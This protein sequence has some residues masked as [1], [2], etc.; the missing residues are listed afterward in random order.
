[1]SYAPRIESGPGGIRAEHALFADPADA[2]PAISTTEFREAL[3]RAATAVTVIATDG[4]NGVA[5]LTC[6][7]VC[8]VCDTP[9]TILFCVNR[10]SAANSVIKANGVMSVNW[11]SA[12]Q[13]DVSQLF[14]GAGQVPMKERFSSHRW[15]SFQTGTPYSLDALVAL[16]CRISAA[17]EIGTHSVFLARVLTARQA[18]PADPLMYCRRAYATTRPAEL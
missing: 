11:L 7:A 6:S 18:D 13:M 2:H 16:E 14:S 9:P 1:M 12:K 15:G 10:K 3:A 4:P 8:S 5:G 17:M